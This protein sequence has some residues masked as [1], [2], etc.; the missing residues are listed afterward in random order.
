MWIA[1]VLLTGTGVLQ[2]VD[3]FDYPNGADGAPSW[4]TE[5]VAWEIQGEALVFDGGDRSFAVFEQ[6]GHGS[7]VSVEAVVT[8]HEKRG[9]DWSLSL[10]HI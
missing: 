2:F 8:V 3:G 4:L 7:E 5:S 6:A 9:T 10:I 1:A